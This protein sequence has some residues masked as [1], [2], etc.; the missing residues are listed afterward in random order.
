MILR[1]KIV[2]ISPRICKEQDF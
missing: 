2:R 1:R